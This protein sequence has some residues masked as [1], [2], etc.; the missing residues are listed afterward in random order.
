MRAFLSSSSA[1]STPTGRSESAQMREAEARGRDKKDKPSRESVQALAVAMLRDQA[2]D[3]A[4]AETRGG[5]SEESD[6]DDGEASGVGQ[7]F[8]LGEDDDEGE[9]YDDKT[10][11]RRAAVSRKPRAEVEVK[12][13]KGH[14]VVDAAGAELPTVDGTITINLSKFIMRRLTPELLATDEYKKLRDDKGKDLTIGHYE[15]RLW[16][17][18]PAS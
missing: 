14:V 15:C 8:V 18:T 10:K 7:R 6:A 3:D 17:S 1:S 13:I 16:S 4:R 2:R 12:K 5:C 11:R 9:D